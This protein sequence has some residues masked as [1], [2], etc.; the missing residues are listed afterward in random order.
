METKSFQSN[1]DSLEKKIAARL[2]ILEN[3]VDGSS[4]TE[5]TKGV[6][7]IL[8]ELATEHSRETGRQILTAC[9]SGACDFHEWLWDFVWYENNEFGLSN[10]ELIAESEWKN[11]RGNRDY[12][13]EFQEDFEK[14][15]AG[16]ASYRLMILEATNPT[17]CQEYFDSLRLVVNKCKLSRAGDRYML[18]VWLMDVKKFR[19]DMIIVS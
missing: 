5:W 17:E 2:A 12:Y 11:I 16:R 7:T 3:Y 14:L 19:F 18:A 10:I 9:K 13:S 4:G 8:L 1:S 15:I 6:N